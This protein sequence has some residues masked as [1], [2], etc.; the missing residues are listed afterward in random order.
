MANEEIRTQSDVVTRTSLNE[1]AAASYRT[2]KAIKEAESK[3]L[4]QPKSQ[5]DP[6]KRRK[7]Y[8]RAKAAGK[9]QAYY[10]KRM[11]ED[12]MFNRKA[13]IKRKAADP[14]WQT[15][16]GRK[17]N[18]NEWKKII[19]Y[20]REAN[21]S[22][23]DLANAL[24]EKW[25][26][27]RRTSSDAPARLK[28]SKTVYRPRIIN[29]LLTDEEIRELNDA[30]LSK[31]LATEV[32]VLKTSVKYAGEMGRI[33]DLRDEN[34]VDIYTLQGED[35][36]PTGGGVVGYEENYTKNRHAQEAI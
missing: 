3:I 8:E 12:P 18:K 17:N 34:L 14:E 36:E 35:E 5:Y 11:E 19:A 1:R 10:K 22:E 25:T 15:K 13:H 7:I 6:Q 30:A 20:I 24:S 2:H 23:E 16:R 27:F 33:D 32:T 21:L 31:G 26:L 29:R 28:T 4:N 9:P